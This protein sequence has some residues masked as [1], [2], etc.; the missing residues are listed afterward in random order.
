[1]GRFFTRFLVLVRIGQYGM[2]P[3]N[4]FRFEISKE[5]IKES[6]FQRVAAILKSLPGG[7]EFPRK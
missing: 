6:K 2:V 4:K 3:Y 7:D 1:M 5:S